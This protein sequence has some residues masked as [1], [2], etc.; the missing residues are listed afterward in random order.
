MEAKLPPF[1]TAL[2]IS[3]LLNPRYRGFEGSARFLIVLQRLYL[4]DL[5]VSGVLLAQINKNEITVT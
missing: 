1:L 5:S 3:L 2:R 4:A